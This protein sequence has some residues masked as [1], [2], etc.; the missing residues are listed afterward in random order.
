M[1]TGCYGAVLYHKSTPLSKLSLPRDLTLN[2][3]L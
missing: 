1:I 2:Q 3:L